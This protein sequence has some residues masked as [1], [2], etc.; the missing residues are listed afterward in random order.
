MLSKRTTKPTEKVLAMAAEGSRAKRKA[1]DKPSIPAVTSKHTKFMASVNLEQT[2]S[3]TTS[4]PNYR[5]TVRSEE[6]EEALHT[7]TIV[8]DSDASEK[9]D[10]EDPGEA[11]DDELSM[12]ELKINEK[13]T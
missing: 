13:L 4:P 10:I 7:D 6:E 9:S 3:N 11:S 5:A 1:T 8:I 2:T 12:S